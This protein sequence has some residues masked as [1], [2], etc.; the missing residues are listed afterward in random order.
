MGSD[1]YVF[2][3]RRS[4]EDILTEIRRLQAQMVELEDRVSSSAK[5]MNGSGSG[6]M[7]TGA[8]ERSG[9]LVVNAA[10]VATERTEQDKD[11]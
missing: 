6:P 1:N 10:I 5:V 3:P 2:I 4:K 9:E 11:K 8:S 7:T